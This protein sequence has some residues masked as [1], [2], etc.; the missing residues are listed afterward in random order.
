MTKTSGEP[1]LRSVNDFRVHK[2]TNIR[3]DQQYSLFVNAD[4]FLS[5]PNP[6]RSLPPGQL[7]PLAPPTL[8]LSSASSGY[9]G[10]TSY[11]A[12]LAEHHKEMPVD[13]EGGTDSNG[14]TQTIDADRAQAGLRVLALLYNVSLIGTLIRKYYARKWFSILPIKMVENMAVATRRI[15]GRGF[16]PTE[17][18]A[19]LSECTIQIFR[20]SSKP[21]RRWKT[22]T[23]DDYTSTFTG[24][25]ARWEAIALL[26]ASA[27]LGLWTH[28]ESDPVLE[29][30]GGSAKAKERLL[31]QISEAT[32]TCIAFC[33][34]AASS[35]EILAF[36]QFTDVMLRTEQYGDSSKSR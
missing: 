3:Y 26:F 23:I 12:V 4:R 29:E 8:E 22:M 19:R 13:V 11:S 14:I 2:T 27:G 10:S 32:S 25:N 9:L 31:T 33:D 18:E 16:G 24:E 35:N 34:H 36:A 7:G 21:L 17:T 1:R 28:H 6:G 20:N 15:W 5:N 30:L